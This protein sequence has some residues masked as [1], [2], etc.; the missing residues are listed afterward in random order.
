VKKLA[1]DLRSRE[2]DRTL[3]PP[4]WAEA[5]QLDLL[6]EEP[7]A[8]DRTEVASV[9]ADDPIY[10]R[11]QVDPRARLEPRE[12]SAETPQVD[13]GGWGADTN[14]ISTVDDAARKGVLRPIRPESAGGEIDDD[15]PGRTRPMRPKGQ[16]GAAG[17]RKGFMPVRVDSLRGEAPPPTPTSRPLVDRPPAAAPPGRAHRSPTLVVLLDTQRRR[18]RFLWRISA[19]ALIVA[20][21]ALVGIQR[22]QKAQREA[23]VAALFAG[24]GKGGTPASVPDPSRPAPPKEIAGTPEY[25]PPQ[26]DGAAYLTVLA[27]IPAWVLIDGLRLPRTTPVFKVPVSPGDH[28][29][30]V[31]DGSGATREQ[32]LRF[33]VGKLQRMDVRLSRRAAP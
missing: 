26:P 16:K 14:T 18:K 20:V 29:V 4:P 22:I 32:E 23:E 15:A 19:L 6:G 33:E 2:E 31:V 11:T 3:G 28:V 27:D 25:V 7:A 21:V 17:P 13:D 24:Q 9:P 12:P 30:M 1:A 10:D 5:F 8:P